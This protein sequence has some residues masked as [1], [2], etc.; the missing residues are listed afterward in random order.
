MEYKFRTK[1]GTGTITPERIFLDRDGVAGTFA[2]KV[3]GS[4]IIRLLVIYSILSIVLIS[5]GIWRIIESDNV[6][7]SFFCVLG[8]ILLW[9]VIASK[10]NSATNVIKRSEVQ[11][12]VVH[13][14]HPPFTRGYL[15]IHFI[16]DG[17]KQKRLIMFPGIMSGGEQEFQRALELIKETGWDNYK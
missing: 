2:N 12:I 16:R 13:N 8:I 11:S 10:N 1:L 9:N 4:S 17:K 3:Y 6:L 15:T 14:P 5:V 7:G